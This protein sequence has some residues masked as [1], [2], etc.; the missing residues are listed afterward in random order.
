MWPDVGGMPDEAMR[1]GARHDARTRRVLIGDRKA[2]SNAKLMQGPKG[3]L[4]GNTAEYVR[5]PLDFLSGTAAK[6]GDVVPLRFVHLRAA[7]LSNPDYVEHV[8]VK[9]RG[10]FVRGNAFRMPLA[11]RIFGNGLFNSEGSDW[12]AQR[13][14]MQPAFSSA[15][16]K[17]YV[18]NIVRC[19]EELTAAWQDGETRDLHA[20]MAHLALRIL[21]RSLFSVDTEA[22]KMDLD[23]AM[24]VIVDVFASP[25]FLFDNYLPTA[26]HRRFEKAVQCLETLAYEL[27][28]ERR[29]SGGG[30]QQDLL[31]LLL[32]RGPNGEPSCRDEEIR[33]QIITFLMAGHETTAVALS[34]TW[35]LLS[36]HPE[37]EARMLQEI[38]QVL[39][40]RTP[41]AEDVI[42]LE[43]TS[44]VLQESMRL[45]PPVWA[46]IQKPVQAFDL[47]GYHV[48]AGTQVMVSQWV[49]HR[50]PRYFAD[51]ASFLPEIWTAQ[52]SGRPHR[53]A[54]FPFGAGPRICIGRTFAT[55]EAI[56]IL[57]TIAPKFQFRTAP[58]YSV[59]PSP[60][61]T[62]RP[63]GGLKMTIA[64]RNA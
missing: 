2:M 43:F 61:L 48:K 8:L 3:G 26:N 31:S 34:W 32:G 14:R 64:A 54:Y 12:Q 60:L 37:V 49:T 25:G 9:T 41:R 17:S 19:A 18:P 27:L 62:L 51:P 40:G 46:L 42:R 52:V 16:L 24:R 47:D 7:L 55:M 15:S 35:Y 13:M 5:S 10:N 4:L 23:H 30:Q 39:G 28:L 29:R 59:T 11:R 22:R 33:D 45:Y 38:A 1:G 57:A 20:E 63:Q 21:A 6:Y 53:C 58:G 36:E 56:L 50:D 44:S